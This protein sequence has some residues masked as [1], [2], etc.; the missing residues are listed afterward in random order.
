VANPVGGVPEVVEDGISGLLVPVGDVE[1]LAGAL[2]RLEGH[3]GERERL[4]RA[5]ADRVSEDFSIA[6]TAARLAA[7]WDA[8]AGR[9][10]TVEV[11]RAS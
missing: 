9:H 1:A 4:A 11:G 2:V 5:A 7:T 10:E 6:T 3:R 8:A